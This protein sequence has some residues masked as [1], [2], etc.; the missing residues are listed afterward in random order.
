MIFFQT[1]NSQRFG[2][3][4]TSLVLANNFYTACI[5]CDSF[6]NF[7]KSLMKSVTAVFSMSNQYI[8]ICTSEKKINDI[9]QNWDFSKILYLKYLQ[10]Q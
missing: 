1:S 6:Y 2:L 4:N 10:N 8:Y 3:I 7:T 5:G 9:L